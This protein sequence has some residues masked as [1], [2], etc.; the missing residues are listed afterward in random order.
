[1]K[2]RSLLGFYMM[3]MLMI[4]SLSC[5]K[6]A[7]EQAEDIMKK[8]MTEGSWIVTDFTENSVDI[9]SSF[10]GWVCKF[11]DDNT[12]I[13]TQGTGTSAVVK[14][15]TWQSNLSAQNIVAQFPPTVTDPLA[16][17]N[18]TWTIASSLPTKGNF[19]QTKG[20]IPYTMEL[21][22]Y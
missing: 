2:L 4:G 17:L 10:N 14:S 19:T 9:T 21:T 16:K 13:A 22:K 18:G 8:L 5:K 7:E 3:G 11:N 1:M 6:A 12:M 15:G 20:G